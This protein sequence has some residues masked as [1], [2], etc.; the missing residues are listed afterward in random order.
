MSRSLRDDIVGNLDNVASEWTSLS[1]E[2]NNEIRQMNEYYSGV[3][4]YFNKA[5][6]LEKAEEDSKKI[7]EKLSE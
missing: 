4:N 7:K 2:T 3:G 1:R 5:D 6:V